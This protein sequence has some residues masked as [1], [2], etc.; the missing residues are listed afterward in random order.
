LGALDPN[1]VKFEDEIENQE[2]KIHKRKKRGIKLVVS[3]KLTFFIGVSPIDFGF[4]LPR[5]T[6]L[7][8]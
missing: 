7:F 6:L 3:L 8:I 4:V 5:I 2:K 1:F